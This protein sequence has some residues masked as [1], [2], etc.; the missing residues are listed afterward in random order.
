MLNA[1]GDG[2]LEALRLR[3][4]NFCLNVKSGNGA[5]DSQDILARG[6]FVVRAPDDG[7]FGD[8]TAGAAGTGSSVVVARAD[9]VMAL[10]PSPSSR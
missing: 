8:V 6:I 7:S 5:G 2:L 3:D 10:P 9:Y 4:E 1:L